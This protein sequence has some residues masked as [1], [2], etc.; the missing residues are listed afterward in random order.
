MTSSPRAKR[1]VD[2]R[3]VSIVPDARSLTLRAPTYR[4][5]VPVTLHCSS[6]PRDD[7]D[8]EPHLFTTDGDTYDQ[9]FA[10]AQASVPDG[11]LLMSIRSA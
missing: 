11:W 9:A 8:A 1:T 2:P 5:L 3:A 10:A 6:R 7:Q 4:A